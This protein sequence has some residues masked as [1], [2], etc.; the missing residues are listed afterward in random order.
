ML[1]KI[2]LKILN[3]FLQKFIIIIQ[4]W[5][6][7][8]YR[9]TKYVFDNINI[10]TDL[11]YLVVSQVHHFHCFQ[12]S[13]RGERQ[14]KTKRPIDFVQLSDWWTVAETTDVKIPI[15]GPVNF[16]YYLKNKTD[17]TDR[18]ATMWPWSCFKVSWLGIKGFTT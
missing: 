6:I 2:H 18:S 15:T 1:Y 9:Y 4:S 3:V 5:D 12:N 13:K 11:T 16:T 10:I 7:I 17:S 14:Q 8:I